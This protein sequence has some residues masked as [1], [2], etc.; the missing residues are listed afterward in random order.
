MIS[1][2]CAIDA[3]CDPAIVSPVLGKGGDH[4]CC[5]IERDRDMPRLSSGAAYSIAQLEQMLN[6]CRSERQKLERERTK[7]A[8]RLAQLDS[9]IH[10]LGGGGGGGNGRGGRGG[11]GGGGRAGGRRVRNEKSLI[12][13]IEGVLGKSGKPMKVGDIADAVQS[14]GY[15]TNSANF[16]GIVNQ[17]LIKD[18]RFASAGRR[19]YQM[20]K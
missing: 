14:G 18:K 17:T 7:V 20:K 16:R 10:S 2:L 6:K 19:L 3:P 15:R 9:R 1:S 11:A 12:E 8:K 4:S 13:M 5:T